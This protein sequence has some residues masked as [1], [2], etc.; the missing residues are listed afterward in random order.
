MRIAAAHCR[1]NRLIQQT[2]GIYSGTDLVSELRRKCPEL[3]F[4]DSGIEREVSRIAVIDRDSHSALAPPPR[5]S[6]VRIVLDMEEPPQRRQGEIYIDRKSFLE[7][8]HEY[9]SFACDLVDA[10]VH[11]SQ[12]E[13]EVGFLKQIHDLMSLSD[14][15]AVSERITRSVLD[16]LGMSRGTLFLHDPRLERYVVSFTND[17]DAHETGEFLP[18]IP[19]DLLQRALS[20]GHSFAADRASGMIVIPLQVEHDL[21]GVIRVPL[22]STESLDDAVVEDV[23][24]YVR[25][26]SS[27]LG[28]IYQLSSSRDLAMRDDLTKAFNRRFFDTYLDEEIE[29]SRR[30]G[31]L[32]SIIFLDLDDLKM[33]NN[34]YGHLTGSRTLQEVAKRVLTAVR[35]IDKV[36]RFGGDEFCIVLPETD[37]EQAMAV[38]NR[39]RKSLTASAFVIDGTVEISVTASFGIATYPTH[40]LSKDDLIRQ[41]DAAMYRVKSTTKNAVGIASLEHIRPASAQ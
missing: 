11:A 1:I 35:N 5:K 9:L 12:L 6:I 26:V 41:A 39:V 25:A 38:A 37:Q 28:N 40:G 15:Q 14:A 2:I 19:S 22:A 23:S 3:T 20:S 31:S 4:A 13:T 36:I 18:G 30:Y 33:V 21:V 7:K 34:F 29:R 16:L 24:H 17:P 10:A 27:V 32:F 8:P